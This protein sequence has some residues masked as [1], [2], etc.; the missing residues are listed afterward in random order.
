MRC[1]SRCD[2]PT[3]KPINSPKCFLPAQLHQLANP[4]CSKPSIEI[5]IIRKGKKIKHT[6]GVA[7]DLLCIID[8]AQLW[9]GY[10]LE[11]CSAA[12]HTG[13]DIARGQPLA[14]EVHSIPFLSGTCS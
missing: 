14:I 8:L 3:L 11:S 5:K 6:C 1:I 7:H 2:Q 12:I 9:L 13:Q 4:V 10:L